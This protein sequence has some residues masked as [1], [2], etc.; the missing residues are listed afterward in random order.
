M[1]CKCC[2]EE[3]KKLTDDGLCKKCQDAF[4]E[5]MEEREM[6]YQTVITVRWCKKIL[7]KLEKLERKIK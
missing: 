5:G 7:K 2:N 3:F 1:K 4:D 6:D